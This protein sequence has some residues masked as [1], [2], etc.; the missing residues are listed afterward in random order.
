MGFSSK[1]PGL[2]L[3]DC[4]FASHISRSEAHVELGTVAVLCPAVGVFALGLSMVAC[5]DTIQATVS[6]GTASLDSNGVNWQWDG[7]SSVTEWKTYIR[8]METKNQILLCSS[9]VQ[10]TII[11]KLYLSPEQLAELPTL[12]TESI[13][14]VLRV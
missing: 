11:P 7:G 6:T 1:P 10:C 3:F 8:W 14:A 13:G 12:L 9:P 2:G 5:P 4:V